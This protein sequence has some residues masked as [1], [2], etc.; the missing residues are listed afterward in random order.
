M[1]RRSFQYGDSNVHIDADVFD[2]IC[3]TS[4]NTFLHIESEYM[5]TH[6]EW[7]RIS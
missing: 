5:V 4:Y 1:L 7:Q 6:S 2:F 3:Y